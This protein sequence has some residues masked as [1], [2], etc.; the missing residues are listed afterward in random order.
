MKKLLIASAV[1]MLMGAGCAANSVKEVTAEP[2]PAPV[3][4]APAAAPTPE[5]V[6]AQS[7]INVKDQAAGNAVSVAFA[8]FGKRG[9]VVIHL[10]E[11]GAPGKIIGNSDIQSEG[12]HQNILVTAKTEAG[13]YYY[14]MLHTD[15]GDNKYA[16]AKDLPTKNDNGEI[17][18]MRFEAEGA[19]AGLKTV[20]VSIQNFAF[21]Q[22]TLT[23]KKGDKVTFTNKD[24]APHTA[25]A[26]AGAFT[27][28]NL[29][30]N[31]SF[32]IDTSTLA[33]GTYAYHCAVHP[34]MKAT[35]I[36]E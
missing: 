5:T 10:E 2:T 6:M 20:A 4:P 31:Q 22:A 35:L 19:S 1:I 14:A 15:N 32:T 7:A 28:G 12:G 29:N 33:A 25:T 13:K 21:S 24:S 3:Q 8:T 26:D 30:M 18:M 16:T 17:V 11:N 34:N 27:S 23:V 36:V 9:F